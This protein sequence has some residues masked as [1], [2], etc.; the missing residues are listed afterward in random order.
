MISK[1]TEILADIA[2][3]VMALIWGA[4]FIVMKNSLDVFTTLQILAIRMA[5]G[6]VV[7]TIACFKTMKQIKAKDFIG[8]FV[9]GI[10]LFGGFYFQTIGLEISTVG[11]SSFLTATY[12]IMIPFFLFVFFKKKPD[13]YNVSSALLTVVGIF[14]LTGGGF[15]L[16]LALGD[17]YTLI[18]SVFFAL[19]IILVGKFSKQSNPIILT[20][21]QLMFTSIISFVLMIFT[22]PLEIAITTST[23]MPLLYLGVVGSG[24]AFLIQNV[25][26]QYSPPTHAGIIMSLESVF[27]T[28]LGVIFLKEAMTTGTI[29]GASII[30]LALVIAESKLSFLKKKKPT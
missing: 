9:V 3:A 2:L 4:S 22:E 12:V 29:I 21:L 23:I 13:I 11:N 6:A 15:R 17:I 24:I 28:T 8:G 5:L 16:N 27:A 20:V 10:M 1:K 18:S 14:F 30:F 25:A 19:H 26:Q 7:L